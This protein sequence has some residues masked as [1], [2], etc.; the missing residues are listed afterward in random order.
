M[1]G[2]PKT[3]EL[4]VNVEKAG[5]WDIV[6]EAIA[7]GAT[8]RMLAKK[9]GVSRGW[10]WRILTSDPARKAEYAKALSE[11]A[12]S[13]AEESLEIVDDA[14]EMTPGGVQK[15][16]LRA[17][18]RQWLAGVDNARYAKQNK[19]D[20]N[21][22]VG[23]LHLDALRRRAYPPSLPIKEAVIEIEPG[24]TP[25]TEVKLLVASSDDQSEEGTHEQGIV[26]TTD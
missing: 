20:V 3:H 13:L 18:L 24:D 6:I 26:E 14:N 7:D 5:G 12:H 17:E 22:T 4:H 23:Q 10:F 16:K 25:S 15:A 8:L 2:T 1:A 9:F 11:R 19:I 21:I